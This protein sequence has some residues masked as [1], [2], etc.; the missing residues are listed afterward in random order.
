MLRVTYCSAEKGAEVRAKQLAEMADAPDDEY[1]TNIQTAELNAMNAALAVLR[2]KQV[3][4][5][6]VED[7]AFYNA[8]FNVNDLGLHGES[9]E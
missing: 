6:Y 5:F 1:R 4:G 2:Y 9:F 7:S 8:L 3:R